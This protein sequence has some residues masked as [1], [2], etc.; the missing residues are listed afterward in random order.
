[1]IHKDINQ[2]HIFGGHLGR[3]LGF[4]K[5]LKS[6]K[7]SLADSERGHLPERFDTDNFVCTL[8]LGIYTLL[9][10]RQSKPEEQS[11]IAL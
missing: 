4:F 11:T 5:M 8:K 9:A 6:I 3:H 2:L 10:G 1:M 7:V